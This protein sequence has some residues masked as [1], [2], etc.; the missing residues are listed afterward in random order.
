MFGLT[1]LLATLLLLREEECTPPRGETQMA[2]FQ[3]VV[4]LY[5]GYIYD[6][7]VPVE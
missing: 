2:Q 4:V 6:D 1:A 7:E 3:I 5:L